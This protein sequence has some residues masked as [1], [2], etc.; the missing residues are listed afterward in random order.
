MFNLEKAIDN[1]RVQMA[2]NG[3]KTPAVLN[4]LESHLREDVRQQVRS[5]V[6]VEQAFNIAVQRLGPACA[7]RAE[8]KKA[9]GMPAARWMGFVC[10]VLV[11]FIVWMSGYTF[12]QMELSPAEQ[13]VAYAAVAF[14][15][16]TACGWRYALPLL[17]V[18][19]N[20][21]GRVTMAI[22]CIASGIV[23]S[24]LFCQFVLAPFERNLDGQVPALGFWAAFP[25][26]LFTCIGVGLMMRVRDGE[27]RATGQAARG[28]TAATGS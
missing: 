20:K 14:S 28:P 24:N 23:L 6:N 27:F 21:R 13:V 8:F 26:A 1:W 9:R 15:L 10:V 2:A 16:L 17:P 4:E 7:L 25:I 18:I 11:G 5:G 19:P 22:V 12:V 3:L